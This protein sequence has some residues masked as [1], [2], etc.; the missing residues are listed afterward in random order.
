LNEASEK[1]E[2]KMKTAS[3]FR[4]SIALL[5]VFLA[6]AAWAAQKGA[7]D[8]IS[9]ADAHKMVK[10]GDALLVCSY[11]DDKC[12]AILLEGAILKSQFE[13]KAASLPKT[14][15]IIFYCA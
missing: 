2:Q 15:P 1:E 9:V 7:I 12:K 14:K 6:A 11:E 5:I 13:S 8:R 10:A 4:I 3:F